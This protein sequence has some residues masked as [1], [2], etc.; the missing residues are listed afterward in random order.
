MIIGAGPAG[1][2][3][4]ETIRKLDKNATI[5]I[6]GDE[7]E[8]PYSRMAIP[9][10]LEENIEAEGTHLRKTNNHFADANIN[11]IQQHVTRVDPVNNVV[12]L[13]NGQTLPWDKLL[14]ATGSH[15]IKPPIPGLD[16]PKV[17]N[18]WT[19]ADSRKIIDHVKKGSHVVQ[20]G[21]GFI[22]CI[23]LEALVRRG[24][25]L[26]VVEMD[27]RMVPRMLDEQC[28]GMLKSWCESK[29]VTVLTET[30]VTSIEDNGDGLKIQLSH[31]EALDADFVISATGVRS[32]TEFL[33]GSGIKMDQGILVDVHLESNLPGIYAAGDVAQGVDFTTGGYSVHAIQPT[34]ADHGIICAKNMVQ[35]NSTRHKGSLQMNVLSTLDLVSTSYG[36]WEGVAGG[37]SSELIDSDRYRYIRLQ[38]SGDKLIGANTLGITQNIGALRGLIQSESH[39]GVWKDRLM[40]NPLNFMDAY[41]SITGNH[42]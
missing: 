23:I 32:N 33:E 7:P 36:A 41:V 6:I 24:A 4:A 19:L 2:V 13:Q 18:C 40:E 21:A 35:G 22:G 25:D 34:A 28:G 14:I 42:A 37:E 29:G 10:F 20:I 16:N 11:V 1:V 31:G 27:N 9:Y 5:T 39:L 30:Q 26:T 3:A 15:P 8:A 12:E 38:F 17:A